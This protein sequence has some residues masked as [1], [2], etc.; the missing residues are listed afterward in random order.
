MERKNTIF[1]IFFLIIS[2]NIISSFFRYEVDLTE[3]KK[4]TLSE[5]SKQVLSNIDDILTIKVYLE[6]NLPTG[7]QMLSSSINNFLINCKKENNFI[8]FE[9]I[10]PND[11]D[12][13]KKKDIYK[14]LQSQGLYPT[15]LTIKK[16]SETSRKII[17]PGLIIYYKEKR[18][19]YYGEKY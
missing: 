5:D 19:T 8:E 10:D 14:Q 6:G 1:I 18:E 7:F 12:E 17:F 2:T 9:F 4:Y 13:T 16:T 15:D 11:N 3:D